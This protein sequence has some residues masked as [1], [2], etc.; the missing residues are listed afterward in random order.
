MLYHKGIHP[1]HRCAQGAIMK[2]T[3]TIAAFALIGAATAAN[4]SGDKAPT[5]TKD[6]APILYN[7]CLN[8]HRAGEAAP[9]SLRDYKEVR[10]W[11]KAI[12]QQVATH[13]MPPW[14]ADPAV[15]TFANSRR[16]SDAEV[17]TIV[18]WVD[19]GAPEG[20]PADLPKTPEFVDGW[21]F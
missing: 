9:M 16:L 18:K 8:C 20:N 7:R 17:A 13:T 2:L 21:S 12:K 11:A 6:V 3:L 10:P 19:G 5:F 1:K 15:N 4:T 14:Y